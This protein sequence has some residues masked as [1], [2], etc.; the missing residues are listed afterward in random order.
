MTYSRFL[1]RRYRLAFEAYTE[2][3]KASDKTD[4]EVFHNI[5][6]EELIYFQKSI[7]IIIIYTI[8]TSVL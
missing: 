4:W 3:E 5:G 8:T 7:I 2:A 1:L 6:K